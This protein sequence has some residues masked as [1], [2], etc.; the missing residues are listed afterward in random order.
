MG[1]LLGGSGA[2]FN[3]YHLGEGG[4]GHGAA[5]DWVFESLAA[6]ALRSLQLS[7]FLMKGFSSP[8]RALK[9]VGRNSSNRGPRSPSLSSSSCGKPDFSSRS[10]L[11][12]GNSST[13]NISAEVGGLGQRYKGW[14]RRNFSSRASA[15]GSPGQNGSIK[16]AGEA[17]GKCHVQKN[18]EIIS[19][20]EPAQNGTRCSSSYDGGEVSSQTFGEGYVDG[21][22][23]D[24]R[25]EL[26]PT[27]RPAETA[28]VS[29]FSSGLTNRTLPI[30]GLAVVEGVS[31]QGL[32]PMGKGFAKGVKVASGV[33]KGVKTAT[34]VFQRFSAPAESVVMGFGAANGV[35]MGYEAAKFIVTSAKISKD[36]VSVWKLT[37]M[38]RDKAA[39]ANAAKNSLGGKTIRERFAKGLKASDGA[40]TLVKLTR[41]FS[42]GVSTSFPSGLSNW[43]LITKGYE[44]SSGVLKVSEVAL[45]WKGGMVSL[46]GKGIL[47]VKGAVSGFG[48]VVK[49]VVLT[50]EI[51]VVILKGIGL[52]KGGKQAFKVIQERRRT[53][54]FIFFKTKKKDV[55]DDMCFSTSSTAAP[56]SQAGAEGSVF[57]P[58]GACEDSI[59][60]RGLKAS[61]AY[62][63][64]YLALPTEYSGC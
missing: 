32:K 11:R 25:L 31:L 24:I 14:R 33:V 39:A 4:G 64:L 59:D 55:D 40:L 16:E 18:A 52:W 22:S 6:N 45:G 19:G 3:P 1:S 43:D 49:T 61:E 58:V 5:R 7:Y 51:S 30:V 56:K 9:D 35:I 20:G 36:F 50:K 48:V 60:K 54:D 34:G 44:V 27:R 26:G 57:S 46:L 13:R 47:S 29:K 17:G 23:T 28:G 41:E 10:S 63:V 53:G 21:S 2:F 15:N 12:V 8:S 42:G 38:Y 62:A 37:K